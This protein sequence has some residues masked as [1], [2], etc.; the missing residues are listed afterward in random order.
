MFRC[1]YTSSNTVYITINDY[2]EKLNLNALINIKI[3]NTTFGSLF[4]CVCLKFDVQNSYCISSVSLN[5]SSSMKFSMLP[6]VIHFF[7]QMGGNRST[8]SPNSRGLAK[9]F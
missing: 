6:S 5:S 9:V 8:C 3:Y 4:I 1:S 2:T 7:T